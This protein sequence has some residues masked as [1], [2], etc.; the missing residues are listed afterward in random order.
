MS[1]TATLIYNPVAGKSNSE[2]DLKIIRETLETEIE[3]DIQMTRPDRDGGEIAQE[4][5]KNNVEAIIASG[6]DGTI[7]AVAETLI[8]QK[9]PL[10]IIPRGTANALATALGISENLQEACQTILQGKQQL[11]DTARCNDQIMVLLAGVGFEAETVDKT[12]SDKKKRWGMLAYI[13]SG[14]EELKEFRQFDLEIETE[15][16]KINISNAIAF[17]V[18]N[19]APP[20]SI[21][22][23]GPRKLIPDDGLL[24]ITILTP[25]DRRNALTISYHLLKSALQNQVAQLDNIGY[26]RARKIS[27][28]ANPKQ[29]IVKDGE[30]IGETPFYVEC[31]PQSL[32][33][34][35]PETKEESPSENLEGEHIVVNPDTSA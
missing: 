14:I 20:T 32:I 31:V 25:D 5:L 15:N 10:G 27:V 18:A 26:L 12:D 19:I 1:R 22:A 35:V 11:I 24:D 9:I 28:T 7:S 16:K 6:G 21:L 23:H 4:A 8:N 17:T 2:Q 33:I 30:I 34:Y 3:L 29:K 13:L